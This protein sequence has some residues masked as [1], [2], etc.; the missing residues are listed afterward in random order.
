MLSAGQKQSVVTMSSYGL[1]EALIKV[2]I[3]ERTNNT[4]I[5]IYIYVCMCVCMYVCMYTIAE[6]KLDTEEMM[7]L[8]SC[9]KLALVSELS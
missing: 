7:N 2:P 5:Y 9:T 4:Y 6:M 1:T 3:S 8:S